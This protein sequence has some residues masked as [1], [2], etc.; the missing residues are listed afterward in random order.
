MNLDFIYISTAI[1]LFQIFDKQS[2]ISRN[3]SHDVVNTEPLLV[4]VDREVLREITAN[5]KVRS[6]SRLKCSQV[7]K[8]IT[9]FTPRYFLPTTPWWLKSMKLFTQAFGRNG[10]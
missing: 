3:V 4:E 9:T 5:V 1:L 2:H 8:I 10:C 6:T 7:Q